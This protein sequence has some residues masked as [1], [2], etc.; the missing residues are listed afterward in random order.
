[1]RYV[2]QNVI[3][4]N[5][6]LVSSCKEGHYSLEIL[7]KKPNKKTAEV[8]PVFGHVNQTTC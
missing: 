2:L 4:R 7:A 8:F 3:L 6:R 5:L 1:M